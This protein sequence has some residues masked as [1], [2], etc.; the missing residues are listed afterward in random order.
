MGIYINK[1]NEGF[2]SNRNSEYVDK[3]G[4]IAI[5]NSTL[6]TRQRF[7]CV[8]RSRRFG[9][10]MAA[11]MLQ[12]YYDHSCDSRSLFADLE[13]ARHPSFEKHLNK[14]PVIFLDM[15]RFTS[16]ND[17]SNVVSEIEKR[18][19]EDVVAAY[20]DVPQ[21]SDDDLMDFL[22]RVA[23]MSGERFVFI[24]DEWDAPCRI[25]SDKPEAMDK[26]VDWLRRMFKDVTAI[27][28]Y[29]GVYMTGILPI[30]KYKTQSAL[31]NFVEYSMVTP[32]SMAGFFGFTADEVAKLSLHYKMDF[33]EMQKWYDGYQIGNEKSIFNPNS[34]MMALREQWCES[35]W[36]K[37]AAYDAVSGYINMNFNGLKDGIIELLGGGRV[38]V[39]PTKFQNDMSIIRSKDDV[40]TLLIHLGYLSYDRQRSECYIPNKEV[41]GELVN[42]V[43]ENKW[44]LV[45][46]SINQSEALLQATLRGDSG[47]VER[48]LRAIHSE[49]TSIFSYNDENSLACVIS[50]A[51]YYARNDYYIHREYP[52]GEGYADL[53]LIPRK[54][55]DS[56]A[57]VIE[58]KY[59]KGTKAAINQIKEKNY[60][61]KISEYTGD[62][63]LV[64]V[65]YDKK[66]KQ[67]QCQIERWQKEA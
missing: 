66:T 51:Y 5:V 20:P 14:Y 67:H 34:V 19:K 59:D 57:L 7:S 24:I 35:Y 52:T 50:L 3:S 32:G 56:P 36:S 40:L 58:L 21:N 9:K 31:N 65:N 44:E 37:T 38:K 29:A 54:N 53:V 39:N 6:N 49:H 63:L 12:A 43:E 26:Y 33:E 27:Q 22:L 46:K 1:G 15:T 18:V 48:A 42:A 41:A 25:Y 11:E 47:Y 23:T 28:T 61:Q 2:Q 16:G 13:I 17:G 64:G 62:I 30:K 4:L 8:T 10:S 45:I 55:V 60:P